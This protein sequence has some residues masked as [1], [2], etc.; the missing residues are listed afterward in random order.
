MSDKRHSGPR[1]QRARELAKSILAQGRHEVPVDI[2]WIAKDQGAQI[3]LEPLEDTVSGVLVIRDGVATIGVNSSHADT[4][5][6][7]TIAHELGHYLLHKQLSHV[8]V[9]A[10]YFRDQE[11]SDG[12]MLHEIEANAFAAELLMPESILRE[13]FGY[14]PIADLDEDAIKIEAAT[15]RVSMQALTIRLTTL[16]LI[17]A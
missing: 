16:G 7:F 2:E 4:R 9:D 15:L 6:R 12:T 1:V 17:S 14:H 11:S 8:F 13:R 5:R 10:V 3:R